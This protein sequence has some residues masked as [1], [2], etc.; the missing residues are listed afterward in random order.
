MATAGRP[1]DSRPDMCEQAHNYCLL[2]ATND[3]LAQF[4]DVSPRTIDRWI[5]ER[6]GND[7]SAMHDH[8]GG[9]A[10]AP[11]PLFRLRELARRPSAGLGGRHAPRRSPGN[12]RRPQRL[13]LP[14]VHKGLRPTEERNAS[15]LTIRGS[16]P[17]I[18]ER[19]ALLNPGQRLDYLG[20]VAQPL[21]IEG[22]G[23]QPISLAASCFALTRYAGQA[24]RS[25]GGGGSAW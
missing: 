24:L 23:S 8:H 6:F 4:L 19:T 12:D 16:G 25:L 5:A 14:A 2:G 13:A 9:R 7:G 11:R 20:K 15:S 21:V 1:T 10:N 3:E 18:Q 22:G 17:A